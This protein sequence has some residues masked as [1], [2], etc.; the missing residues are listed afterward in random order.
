MAMSTEGI[1][2]CMEIPQS[3]EYLFV[4]GREGLNRVTAKYKGCLGSYP[5]IR[6]EYKGF[7]VGLSA[8]SLG[9]IVS[10]PLSFSW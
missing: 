4:S 3:T 9:D 7:L 6:R 8:A 1:L 2:T 10:N 5:L